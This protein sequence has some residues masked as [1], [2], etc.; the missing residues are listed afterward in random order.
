M[1][2]QDGAGRASPGLS[3]QGWR[4]IVRAVH[5]RC[6]RSAQV[7]LLS[8]WKGRLCARLNVTSEVALGW[9]LARAR[10]LRQ[11]LGAAYVAV[12]GA[13]GNSF[14]QRAVPPPAELDGDRYTGA[15]AAALATLGNAT[16]IS[17]GARWVPREGALLELHGALNMPR[18][19]L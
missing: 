4:G 8:T 12:E 10:R 2:G 18:V 9:Y 3:A 19:M 7:P 5:W 17:A 13:E 1:V 15:L 16:I 14:L 11:L 6:S